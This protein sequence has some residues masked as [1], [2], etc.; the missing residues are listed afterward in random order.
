[1]K[2]CPSDVVQAIGGWKKKDM[3][4]R[5]KHLAP[6]YMADIYKKTVFLGKQPEDSGSLKAQS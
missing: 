6:D 3:I 2:G 1:M 4:E 5:Y